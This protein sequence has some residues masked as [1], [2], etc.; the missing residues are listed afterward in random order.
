MWNR[1]EGFCVTVKLLFENTAWS[2]SHCKLRLIPRPKSESWRSTTMV[3]KTT[4]SLRRAVLIRWG[5]VQEHVYWE[6]RASW[7][8]MRAYLKKKCLVITNRFVTL[9]YII[10]QISSNPNLCTTLWICAS[11]TLQAKSCSWLLAIGLRPS[12][13]NPRLWQLISAVLSHVH[14]LWNPTWNR[15]HWEMKRWWIHFCQSHRQLPYLHSGK[16]QA[17]PRGGVPSKVGPLSNSKTREAPTRCKSTQLMLHH[18]R[19]DRNRAILEIPRI[20][21]VF[22]SMWL[23]YTFF[24]DDL[25]EPAFDIERNGECFP[26]GLACSLTSRWRILSS[27]NHGS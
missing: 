18:L 9:S 5:K 11:L 20:T 7:I 26:R 16:F 22:A 1:R 8:S 4:K 27:R 19:T 6:A 14:R 24:W 21:C 2:S 10:Y 23:S 13:C 17:A 15:L 25:H 12:F 3:L